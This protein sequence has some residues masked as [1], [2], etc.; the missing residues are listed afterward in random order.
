MVKKFRVTEAASWRVTKDFR[1]SCITRNGRRVS[2]PNSTV[3]SN[4]SK[5]LNES[6]VMLGLQHKAARS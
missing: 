2:G 1:A 3:N 4:E 6:R 5:S